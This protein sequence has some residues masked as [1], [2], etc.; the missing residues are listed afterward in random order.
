MFTGIEQ[1]LQ[2]SCF[3]SSPAWMLFPPSFLSLRI[4]YSFI[5]IHQYAEI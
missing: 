5:S 1:I 4:F 3:D 2:M